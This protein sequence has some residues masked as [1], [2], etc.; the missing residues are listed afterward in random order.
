MEYPQVEGDIDVHDQ[1]NA[2]IRSNND[3]NSRQKFFSRLGYGALL[4]ISVCHLGIMIFPL[5]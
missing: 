5:F 2:E 1:L 4:I 3:E